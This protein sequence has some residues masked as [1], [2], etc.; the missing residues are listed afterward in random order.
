MR[1][2]NC[3]LELPLGAKFCP[4]CG[5]STESGSAQA[6]SGAQAGSSAQVSQMSAA[7][8]EADPAPA[9]VAQHVRRSRLAAL[10]A[11]PVPLLALIIAFMVAATAYAAYLVYTRVV[12][13]AMEQ[14]RIEREETKARD[15]LSPE[16]VMPTTYTVAFDANGGE[17]QTD[18]AE[19]PADGSG[20]LPDAVPT[21]DGYEFEGWNTQPDGSGEAFSAGQDV[22]ALA[23]AGGSVTLYAQWKDLEA[24]AEA[25]AKREANARKFAELVLTTLPD[26]Y[27]ESSGYNW[28]SM[29]ESIKLVEPGSPLAN[30][31]TTHGPDDG[32]KYYAQIEPNNLQWFED[33]TPNSSKVIADDGSVVTVVVNV[34]EMGGD[35]AGERD[36]TMDLTMSPD[37]LV[38]NAEVVSMGEG[39]NIRGTY[40]GTEVTPD[41]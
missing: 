9:S 32:S 34:T 30:S 39:Q 2:G 23:D 8:T 41:P 7:G 1:C 35:A 3:G 38:T 28:D 22:T 13:P 17:G 26:K 24:E 6:G 40:Y 31:V 19:L 29:S 12:E 5:H 21:R 25:K 33:R 18:S 15:E 10:R 16:D 37:G 14:A 36:I 20:A 27:D 11:L 4:R